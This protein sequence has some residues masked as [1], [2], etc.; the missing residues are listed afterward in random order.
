M[1][2]IWSRDLLWLFIQEKKRFTFNT[3]P[4]AQLMLELLLMK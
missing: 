3:K 2:Q 1:P 4:G